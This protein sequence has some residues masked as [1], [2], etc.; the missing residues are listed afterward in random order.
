MATRDTFEKRQRERAKKA[1]AAAK[2][3]RRLDKDAPVSTDLDGSH[4]ALPDDTQPS[5]AELLEAIEEIHRQFEAAELGYEE[6]EKKK[7]ALLI[8]LPVD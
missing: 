2:R 7:A 4:E 8:Q 3:D 5:V 6:F 1:K